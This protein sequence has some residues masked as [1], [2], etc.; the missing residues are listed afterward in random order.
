[1]DSIITYAIDEV[2]EYIYY[3]EEMGM[4]RGLSF[5]E[6]SLAKWAAKEVIERMKHCENEPPLTIIQVFK[7]EMY[8]Y[9]CSNEKTSNIF[10]IAVDVANDLDDRL[11]SVS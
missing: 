11:V 8:M 4:W 9:A 2:N 5:E 7:E 1:M 6:R 10:S 3:I